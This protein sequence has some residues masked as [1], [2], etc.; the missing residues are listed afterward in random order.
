LQQVLEWV[1][2]ELGK[3]VLT[4]LILLRDKWDQTIFHRFTSPSNDKQSKCGS[5]LLSILGFL[6]NDL[7]F[8]DEILIDKILFKNDK[9]DENVFINLFKKTQEKGFYLIFFEFLANELNLSDESLKKILIQTK[10]LYRIAQIKEKENRAVILNAF[11]SKFGKTFLQIFHR[12]CEKYSTE[13]IV[14]FLNLVAEQNNLEFLKNFVS[15]KNSK[16]QT[17][18]LYFHH[19]PSNLFNMLEWLGTKFENDENFLQSFLLQVDENS[20][21]FLN[22]VLKKCYN[23][24]WMTNFFAVT[25]NFLLRN[26]DKV[27]VKEI[28]L[29]ENKKGKNFLNIICERSKRRDRHVT[30]VLDTLFRNFQNDQD[31][32]TKLINEKSKKNREVK[33]FMKHKLN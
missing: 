32:F 27:F 28:L 26:F 1:A 22:F 7:K 20:D 19:Y 17:I 30:S 31:F 6:K 10:F 5:K 29:L 12:C 15:G 8:E 3:E 4:E 25:F 21:S 23:D 9:N 33:D 14:N 11:H 13:Y 18:L 24:G 16:K 2:R